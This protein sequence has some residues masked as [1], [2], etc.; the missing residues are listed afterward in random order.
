MI[1]ANPFFQHFLNTNMR[2][3]LAFIFI[4]LG[5]KFITAQTITIVDAENNAPIPHAHICT[6]S[7]DNNEIFYW[8]TNEFGIAENKIS[9]KAKIAISFVGFKTITDSI[10]PDQYYTFKLKPIT[11]SINEVVITGQI[12]PETVDK[13]IYNVQVINSVD[14]S[15]KAATNLADLL[16][17]ELNIVVNNNGILG[18]SIQLQGLSGEHVKILIDGVPVIGRQ[19]GN[20]DLGQLNL[21]NV[22]HIEIVEGPMSVVYGSNALA[23]AINIITKTNTRP[24]INTNLNAYYESVGSYNFD[25]TILTN[26]KNHHI[27]IMA[28]RNYFDG[29]SYD[30]NNDRTY[31]FSPKLQYNT[32]LDYGYSSKKLK[33]VLSQE[34][35]NETLINYGS[36]Y[37][38]GDTVIN[39]QH[40]AF[41][42]AD[43]ENHITKRWNSKGNASYKIGNNSVINIIG[44]YSY[45]AKIKNTYNKNLYRLS[46]QLSADTAKHDTTLFDAI[47]T[48][49]SY[50]TSA[51]KVEM[52]AG[53]DI[54]IETGNGKRITETQKI[55]D[56]AAFL[57][58]KYKPYNNFN[59][60]AGLRGI[61][62]T[63]YKAPLVYSLNAKYSPASRLNLRF[64][65][66]KGFRSPSI[67]ELYLYFVDVNHEV[68]G[69]PDLKA[70]YSQ[71][72]N[73]SADYKVDKNKNRCK[74]SLKLY[75]NQIKN[76]IDFLYDSINTSK[77]DYINIDGVYKTIGGQFDVEYRLHPRFTLKTG[78]NYYGRS[79]IARLDEYT[80]TPDYIASINYHNMAYGFRINLYYKYNGKQSQ[81]YEIEKEG[82]S[83]IEERFIDA[84]NMMDFT[85]S[86]PFFNDVLNISTGIKNMLNVTTV[87]GSGG[88]SGAHSGGGNGESSIAY[89][90]TFFIKL[91]YNFSKF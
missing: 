69:N 48:R 50:S 31:Y 9:K 67:K 57:S 81:Y 4:F 79:K 65:Y 39:N 18:S 26:L 72:Y 75:H 61:Y 42:F 40:F 1:I 8:V 15:N 36:K 27:S 53:Y 55:G 73:F 14:I 13:S 49:G 78:F 7:A 58:F 83:Q 89:G 43:D 47:N 24:K 29:F 21:Q 45:Y 37:H 64:S 46:E 3:K 34:Y 6:E 5:L 30:K 32:N 51:K 63:K 91:N 23:G 74:Y 71:N 28:G 44:A 76:K 16:A 59:I 66:G 60:Q 2:I 25:A 68:K 84:Y 10:L 52:Q 12:N 38:T 82:E 70:E 86:K 22:D 62:N 87:N 19:N 90:R 54:V 88:S 11:E 80:F 77:A 85:I 35:F 41:P 20:I 33:L 17:N 56:Y